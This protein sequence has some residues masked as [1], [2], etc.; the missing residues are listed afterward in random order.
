MR[1][2]EGLMNKKILLLLN[3]KAGRSDVKLKLLEIIDL[4]VKRGYDVNVHPTQKKQEIPQF[5]RD[6]GAN[7][8]LVVCCGGDGTLNETVNGLMTMTASGNEAEAEKRPLL[9]FIPSGTVMIMRQ[10]YTFPKT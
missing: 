7:Y 3:P 8:S 2:E 10:A 5:I 4:F 6:E 1:K 9:G